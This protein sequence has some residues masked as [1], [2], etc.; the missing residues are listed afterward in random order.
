MQPR[1]RNPVLIYSIAVIALV[2]VASGWLLASGG[3]SS[4][5]G[6]VHIGPSDFMEAMKGDPAA[7]LVDVRTPAEFAEG[8]LPGALNVELDRLA[9][10]APSLLPDK[11]A[12]LLVYCRS[13]NRSG[14]AVS[15]LKNQG[16]SRL[17]NMTGGIVQWSR[18]GYPVTRD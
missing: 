13:G 7:I 15:M 4:S 12:H 17:V 16:Y 1:S 9:D 18:Q 11:N 14:F 3:N 6:V 5:G 8:H 10:L 2:V